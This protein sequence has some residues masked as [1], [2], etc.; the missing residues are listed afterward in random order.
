M[1][2]PQ[3]VTFQKEQIFN[4]IKKTYENGNMEQMTI[5][6]LMEELK[7]DLRGALAK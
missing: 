2:S 5:S 3:E 1:E 4:L 7:L 6:Q